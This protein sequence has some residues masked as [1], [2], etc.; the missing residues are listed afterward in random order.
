MRSWHLLLRSLEG[1][2]A[3]RDKILAPSSVY[4]RGVPLYRQLRTHS[5]VFMHSGDHS[6]LVALWRPKGVFGFN[7]WFFTIMPHNIMR[8]CQYLYI[9]CSYVALVTCRSCLCRNAIPVMV[10]ASPVGAYTLTKYLTHSL[11]S[12]HKA[13]CLDRAMYTVSQSDIITHICGRLWE[14]VLS[15]C[16]SVTQSIRINKRHFL[17]LL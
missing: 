11:A 12:P 17:I 1:H 6:S 3:I 10:N 5:Y 4:Y 15:V 13:R 16:R 8:I 2:L 14:S 9:H 7:S